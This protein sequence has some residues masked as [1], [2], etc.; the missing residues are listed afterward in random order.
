MN[1][2]AF[3][4][5]REIDL[6]EPSRMA[7]PLSVAE[8]RTSSVGPTVAVIVGASRPLGMNRRNVGVELVKGF[9]GDVRLVARAWRPG[10]CAAVGYDGPRV[11]PRSPKQVSFS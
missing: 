9:A 2:Q 6:P 3:A 11:Q 1:Q 4:R 8:A 10:H 5:A 7:D